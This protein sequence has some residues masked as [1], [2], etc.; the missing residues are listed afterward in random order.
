LFGAT[1]SKLRSRLHAGFGC[2]SSIMTLGFDNYVLLAI[3][4]LT[5]ETGKNH[6]QVCSNCS[7]VW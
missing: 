1:I 7:I 6:H 2:E 4:S 5:N 3:L